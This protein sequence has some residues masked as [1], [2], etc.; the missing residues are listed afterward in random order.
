MHAGDSLDTARRLI[1]DL[2][3]RL[4]AA[5]A[6]H[7]MLETQLHEQRARGDACARA[8]QGQSDSNVQM[9]RRV[10][11]MAEDHAGWQVLASKCRLLR[12]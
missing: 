7:C 8:L 5:A 2:N 4:R 6:S 11:D 10:S 1:L 12:L 3:S 9:Q